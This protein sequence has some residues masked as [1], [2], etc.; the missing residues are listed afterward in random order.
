MESRQKLTLHYL[1]TKN[2]AEKNVLIKNLHYQPQKRSKSALPATK[3]I[4]DL[5]PI[6]NIRHSHSHSRMFEIKYSLH[7]R[8]R[9]CLKLNIRFTFAFANVGKKHIRYIPK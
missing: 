4:L 9:E 6:T 7:I 3:G 2:S 5:I 1:S 8:I